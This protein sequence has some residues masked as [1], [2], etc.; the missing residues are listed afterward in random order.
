MKFPF[1]KLFVLLIFAGMFQ[2][3]EKEPTANVLQGEALGTTY[4]IKYY[5][6]EDIPLEKALDSIFERVNQSMSTYREG[7]DISRL[8]RNDSL[9]RVDSLFQNVFKLSEKVYQESEGYFD[10]TVGKL[11]NFYGFGPEK[12]EVTIDSVRIDS[13]RQYVGLDKIRITSEGEVKKDIPGIYIDFNAIAKGYTIDL[14]GH[15]LDSK[16]VNNYLVELGGELLARGENLEKQAVWTVG[17][18]DPSQTEERTLTAAVQ[19][20]DRAMATSGN[21]RKNR[22]DPKTGKMYVHTVNPLTGYAEKSDVLSASVL[23]ENCALADAYATAFMA[24]G[25]ERSK[26]MLSKTEGVDVYLIYAGE[27]GSIEEFTTPGF[28]EVLIEL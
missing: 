15:Y 12:E 14:I 23:A 10:P 27:N 4:S 17:V 3:C 11:V 24:M 19:L 22:L 6:E 13:L 7:S 5:S 28:L 2:S 16:K 1:L 9:V 18:D 8:N 25:L 21:Y 26:E 20:K